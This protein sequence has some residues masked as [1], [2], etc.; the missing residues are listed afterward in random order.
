MYFKGSEVKYLNL[1]DLDEVLQIFTN[2]EQ[3]EDDKNMEE[4]E[5]EDDYEEE[6]YGS[7]VI[8]KSLK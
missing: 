1:Q 4:E 3:V 6:N 7:S 8:K 2:Q 5:D